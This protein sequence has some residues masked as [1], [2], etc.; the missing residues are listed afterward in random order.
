MMS[1][2][3]AAILRANLILGVAVLAVLL[4]RVPFRRLFGAELAYTLWAAPPLATLATLLPARTI[5]GASSHP[6]AEAVADVSAEGIS[7]WA[8]GVALVSATLIRAQLRFMAEARAGRTSASVV[9][10]ISPR[11]ILPREDG[12]FTDAER[13]LIRAHEREHV[14]RQDP[15]ATALAAALQALCWF[16]PLA[17]I[18][19]RVM[20]LDQELACDAAVLRKRPADRGLY[21]R[22]LL[23]SQ[24]ATQSLPLGCYWPARSAHPLEVRIGLLRDT[25]RHDGLTGPMLIAATLFAAT[26]S[27]WSVQP[28]LPRQPLPIYQL[29]AAQQGKHMSVMLITWPARPGSSGLSDSQ[30]FRDSADSTPPG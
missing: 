4:L 9:G 18:G 11:I 29:W 19:G 14:A 24:L 28:P 30:S 17:W 27:A 21:A 25:R 8:M 20:R 22:T 12:T 23:K 5:L 16:N 6:L 15:R 13:A 1:E 2:I 3:L 7:I 10:V 26:V